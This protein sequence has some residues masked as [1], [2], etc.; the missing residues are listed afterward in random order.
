ME[1]AGDELNAAMGEKKGIMAAGEEELAREEGH[2]GRG[3]GGARG[4]ELDCE[5]EASKTA[6]AQHDNGLDGRHGGCW[7]GD[8]HARGREIEGG[9][10]N[11]RR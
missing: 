5:R 11:G 6:A 4:A 9:G 8:G 10:S 3:R 7:H 2:R 1:L